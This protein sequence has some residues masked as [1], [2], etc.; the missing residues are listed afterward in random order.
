MPTKYLLTGVTGGLGARIL[1]DMLHVHHLDPHSIIATSRDPTKRNF[2]ESQGLQFR[3]ADYNDPSTLQAAFV[4]VKNFLFMSSST[5]DT[6]T[7]DREHANVLHAAKTARV[8]KVWYVSLALGGFGDGSRIGFQQAH[9]ATE[10]LLCESGLDFVSLRAG[11]YTDAFPLSLNWYPSSTSVLLPKITPP[12]EQGRIAWTSRDELGEAMATLLSMGVEAFPNIQPRTE[13]NIIL[14]TGTETAPLTDLIDA[15][16][17]ARG[18]NL[19]VEIVDPQ[20]WIDACTQD[21]EGGKPKAWFEARLVF[22]QG[23]C[24]GDAAVT[25]PAMETLLGRTP[26]TGPQAVERLLKENPE[27]TWHQNHMR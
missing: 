23:V 18:T 13:K 9:Y 19:S 22:M 1:H 24:D 5:R 17:T 20:E 3:V 4:D 14:L 15:I 8:G 10:H 6:P 21:D 2:F 26:E 25:D 11:V 7:R 16:N 27:Y 12:V